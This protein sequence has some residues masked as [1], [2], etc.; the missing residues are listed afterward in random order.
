LFIGYI[1]I[2]AS[3]FGRLLVKA[4]GS[5]S[6]KPL[7][8]WAVLSVLRSLQLNMVGLPGMGA[9]YCLEAS[10]SLWRP[11]DIPGTHLPVVNY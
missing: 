9:L 1:N 11:L 2:G 5:P 3:G 4:S 10:W 7:K 8:L 6:H